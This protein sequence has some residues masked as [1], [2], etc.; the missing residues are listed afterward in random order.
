MAAWTRPSSG[1]VVPGDQLPARSGGRAPLGARVRASRGIWVAETESVI[2]M[3]RTCDINRGPSSTVR[4]IGAGTVVGPNAV[5]GANVR[6]GQ[7]AGWRPAVSMGGPTSAMKRRFSRLPRSAEPAGPEIPGRKDAAGHRPRQHLS[8]VRHHPSRHRSRR[9]PHQHRRP[10]TCSWRTRTSPTTAHRQRHDFR[11]RRDAGRNWSRTS[12]RSRRFPACASSAASAST[13]SSA[14]SVDKDAL[15][16]PSR[17]ATG[18]H[19]RA[20]HEI[21]LIAGAFRKRRS[22]S[23]NG[24]TGTCSSAASTPA[25][26]CARECSKTTP[27]CVPEAALSGAVHPQLAAG[28]HPPPAIRRTEEMV[29][30]E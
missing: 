4:A 24:P 7:T 18:P 21:G 27:W 10:R 14:V 1:Q 19:L 17:W 28:R 30:D 22:A 13:P 12:R 29:A 11:Q 16:T 23:S 2:E 5:V 9:R 25:A 26:P 3:R 20:Q 6:V 8:R 15:R